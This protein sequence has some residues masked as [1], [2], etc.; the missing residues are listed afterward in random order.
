MK[1]M[2]GVIVA[3]TTPFDREGKLDVKALEEETE[4]LI[5]KGVHCL[6][7]CGTT[8]EM[9]LMSVEERKLVAE[10]VVKKAAGRCIV[11]IHTGAVALQDTIAL[12]QHAAQIGADGIGVV[13]PAF[14]HLSERAMVEFYQTVAGSVPAD[15]PIY[16]Y[17]IPQCSTN[18]ITPAVCEQV[19]KTCPNVVGIKYSFNDSARILEYLK[20][21]GYDFSVLVGPDKLFLPYML[22]GCQGT[23]SGTAAV[24]PEPFVAIYNAYQ[25][26]D[27]E[28]ALRLQRQANELIDILKGGS[29]MSYFKEGQ[30]LRG[31]NGGF[32]RRPLL[33]MTE[34]ERQALEEQ[35]RPYVEQYSAQ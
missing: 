27:Y 10:T 18:D 33:D 32:M 31:L 3:M 26:G 13:T 19:R 22:I 14:F 6:Y 23:V 35:L 11:Y 9:L 1:L 20:T 7:P 34:Q 30:K 15:F 29:D 28:K 5:G 8:G 17:N 12:S 2:H 21:G 16:L 24:F 4:F 25:Q